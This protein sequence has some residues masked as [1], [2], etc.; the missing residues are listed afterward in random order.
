MCP[1]ARNANEAVVEGLRQGRDWDVTFRPFS[2]AQVHVEEGQPSVFEDISKSGILALQWGVA[3]RDNDP[4]NLPA[5]HV[6]LFGAR[7]D[8]G[9]NISDESVILAALAETG[10]DVEEIAEI[11]ASGAPAKTLAFEHTEAVD[12]WQVFG[13]PT[14]IQDG[15][16]TF[17]RFMSRGDVEH[18]DRALEML[19][20]QDM[21][22][23][24]R[25]VAP[26]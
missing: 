23:F 2:L 8:D 20:W 12:R 14:F 1:F 11:V 24:K 16:A 5:A 6:A 19:D 13:V 17:M 18:L 4:E 21:N 7:H 9:L 10:V 26:R 15:V 25:T 3:I 22:E